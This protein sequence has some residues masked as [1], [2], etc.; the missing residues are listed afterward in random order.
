MNI[1]NF[2]KTRPLSY[3]ALSAF[4]DPRYGSPEKWYKIYIL[5]EKQKSKEMA[6]GSMI[7]KK[8][9]DDPLFIPA[10][11]RYPLMQ[12]E[13]NVMYNKNIPMIGK[14]DWL[15]LDKHLLADTKTGKAI[16]NQKRADDSEQLTAYLFFIYIS[17]KIP[18]EKFRCF[19][20]WLPTIEQ[21]DFKINFRDKEVRPV[22]FETK[23]TLLDILQFGQKVSTTVK[24]MQEYINSYPQP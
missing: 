1:Y 21:G 13:F 22:T 12:Y 6:F 7:D 18:P 2:L 9:Q 24:A 15:D 5:G 11:P 23:R 14:P 4:A 8:L 17:K 3:S 19:I 20:H 10:H 16:W